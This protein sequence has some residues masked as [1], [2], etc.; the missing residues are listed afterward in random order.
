ML[1]DGD[2]P[3]CIKSDILLQH[4]DLQ[5]GATDHSFCGIPALAASICV[6]SD[7]SFT[8]VIY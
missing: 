1:S 5:L 8:E 7:L 4:N 2:I 3:I 6:F